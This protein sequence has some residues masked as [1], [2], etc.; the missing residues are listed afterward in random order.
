MTDAATAAISPAVRSLTLLSGNLLAGGIG[1]SRSEVRVTDLMDIAAKIRPDVFAA[2]ECLYFDE[3]DHRL[4]HQAE[5]L[6]G[7]RGVLGI[8]PRTRMHTAVF[9]RAPLR[10]AEHRVYSGG[11]WHHSV[12]HAV[13]VWDA[14]DGVP[15]GRLR[16]AS[17]HLSPRNPTRRLL[18]IAELT[19]YGAASEPAV[20]LGDTNTEDEHTDL[21]GASRDMLV[22][23]ARLGTRIPDT[24]PID[25]LRSAGI[26][27]LADPKTDA[28]AFAIPREPPAR[29][30]GHWPGKQVA[31]RP[32]RI[33]ANAPAAA[34]VTEF[35]VVTAARH[36]TDHD[37]PC[38]RLNPAALAMR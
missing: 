37:W 34:A 16:V 22:R 28:L 29:T 4:F 23:Y 30:T 5:E 36:L 1:R 15:A 17:V 31:G 27:D 35:A 11:I 13:V 24:A 38:A 7:M 21:S 19:D 18:E 26:S 33:L 12:T 32:D 3:N 10:I 14:H 6:L 9:V 8:S 2:Q 20:L 25:L